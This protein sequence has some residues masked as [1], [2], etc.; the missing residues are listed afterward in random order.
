MILSE[1][2]VVHTTQ[3]VLGKKKIDN[4]FHNSANTPYRNY[5]LSVQVC[6]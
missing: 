6:I 4:F 5:V 3:T 1:S 2:Y